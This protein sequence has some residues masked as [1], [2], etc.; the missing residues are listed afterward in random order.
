MCLSIEVAASLA[1]VSN[2]MSSCRGRP[3]RLPSGIADRAG[4]TTA[5]PPAPARSRPSSGGLGVAG[6]EIHGHRN[7]E[8]RPQTGEGPVE[9][10]LLGGARDHELVARL[11]VLSE[12][13]EGLGPVPG[14]RQDPPSRRGPL[15]V[16]AAMLASEDGRIH[17][18]GRDRREMAREAP[19]HLAGA[20]V[21]QGRGDR[22]VLGW[23]GAGGL[24][25]AEDE[26]AEARGLTLSVTRP[27]AE[28]SCAGDR[29]PAALRSADRRRRGDH[30]HAPRQA[31]GRSRP[32]CAGLRPLDKETQTVTAD[33]HGGVATVAGVWRG[34]V[35]QLRRQRRRR[36][37]SLHRPHSVRRQDS[38]DLGGWSRGARGT[39]RLGGE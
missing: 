13:R 2:F 28:P 1:A 34:T 25:V 33:R 24:R 32:G 10:L 26:G 4:D 15:V 19:V 39:A 30:G 5:P 12:P 8:A 7:D 23:A 29:S 16:H 35:L 37:I 27:A 11:G 17:R 18:A 21:A 22:R 36:R 3:S 38:M 14:A 31:R 6:L 20:N 9:E